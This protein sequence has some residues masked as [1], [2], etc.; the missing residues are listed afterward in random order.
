MWMFMDFQQ[1]QKY[2][3]GWWY[4]QPSE[5]WWSESQLGWNN[6]QI[7]M[8]SHKKMFQTTNQIL[9]LVFWTFFQNIN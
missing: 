5:K 4:T 6:F 8:E 1:N 7:I 2:I 9:M 3:S